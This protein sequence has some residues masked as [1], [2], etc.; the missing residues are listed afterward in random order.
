[1][2]HIDTRE[3]SMTDDLRQDRLQWLDEEIARLSALR[4]QRRAAEPTVREPPKQRVVPI[5]KIPM[6]KRTMAPQ[7]IDKYGKLR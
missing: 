3:P 1:M 5:R 2:A 4:R 6:G 7:S